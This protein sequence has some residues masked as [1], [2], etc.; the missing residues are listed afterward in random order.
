M[1]HLAVEELHD[2]LAAIRESPADRGVLKLI[3]QPPLT[4]RRA[5]PR[6]DSSCY[7]GAP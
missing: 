2:G 5:R 4:L 7:R 6:G 3:V 1:R